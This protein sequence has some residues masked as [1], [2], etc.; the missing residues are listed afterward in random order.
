VDKVGKIVLFKNGVG[1]DGHRDAHVFIGVHGCVKVKVLKIA[2]HEA[3]V[4]RGDDDAVDH[5]FDSGEIGSLGAN[6]ASVI[7]T[8]A[9]N[10]ET[11]AARVGFF[12]AKGG[13]DAQ[14]CWLFVFWDLVSLN[15]KH[16]LSAGG[17]VGAVALA[18]APEFVFTGF[19]PEGTF[20]TLA[21]FTVFGEL[22]GVRVE[23]IAMEGKVLREIRVQEGG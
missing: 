19:N 14:I 1:N 17:H 6:V 9:T 2:S 5:D 22:A 8:V 21:K 10:G 23:S 15:E 20:A 18:K 12:G 11:N 13:N 16:G 7:D 3:G 4:E